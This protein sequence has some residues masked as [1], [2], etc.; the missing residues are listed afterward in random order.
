MTVTVRRIEAR[1]E[2][3]W[4]VLLDGYTRFYERAPDEALTR[5]AWARIMDVTRPVHAIV[6]DDCETGV[7]GIANYT[8]LGNWKTI[9]NIANQ[10]FN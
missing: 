4:R 3:R 7:I 10:L 9:P 1:D 6:A 5:H 8:K 2:A